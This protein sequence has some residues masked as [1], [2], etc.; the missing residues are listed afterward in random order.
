MFPVSSDT[1]ANIGPLWRQRGE[2]PV[3]IYTVHVRR[4]YAVVQNM[5]R[6]VKKIF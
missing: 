2:L 6:A 1:L 3:I 5:L 4:K